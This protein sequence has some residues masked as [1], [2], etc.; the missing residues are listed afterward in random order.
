MAGFGPRARR[1]PKLFCSHFGVRIRAWARSL[2]AG[3]LAD[4]VGILTNGAERQSSN[5]GNR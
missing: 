5:S 3:V 1:R 4:G 2:V